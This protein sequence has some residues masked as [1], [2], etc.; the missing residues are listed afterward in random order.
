MG[1]G[2]G[3]DEDG[4][5]LV[6]SEHMDGDGGVLVTRILPNESCELPGCAFLTMVGNPELM[7]TET[8]LYRH[9]GGGTSVNHASLR[10]QVCEIVDDT[11]FIFDQCRI[12]QILVGNHLYFSF[13]E[14]GRISINLMIGTSKM[15]YRH[16]EKMRR[17]GTTYP[18]TER[19]LSK[20]V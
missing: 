11:V 16:R 12:F 14:L 5:L 3:M 8:S 9:V 13:R 6:S 2:V 4:Y 10:H 18:F 20:G 1:V 19:E 7:G 15:F 17:D